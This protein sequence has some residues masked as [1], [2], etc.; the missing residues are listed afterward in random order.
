M[1]FRKGRFGNPKVEF[2]SKVAEF[3]GKI[4]I[5]LTLI[6][7]K[8]NFFVRFLVFFLDMIDFVFYPFVMHSGHSRDFKK[9]K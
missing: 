4:V 6:F 9:K 8:N 3:A 5:D 7:Y 1:G 2:S